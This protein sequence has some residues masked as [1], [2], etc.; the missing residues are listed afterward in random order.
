MCDM[1]KCFWRDGATNKYFD[2]NFELLLVG[3]IEARNIF[4]A[5]T[6]IN[7]GTLFGQELVD[8]CRCKENVAACLMHYVSCSMHCI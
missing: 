7:R 4:V 1:I 6:L 5:D 8:Q 2:N 3:D